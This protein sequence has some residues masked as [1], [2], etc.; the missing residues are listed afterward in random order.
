M[1][2]YETIMKLIPEGERTYDL[3]EITCRC[4]GKFTAL[5]P[6]D[7]RLMTC[8]R[9]FLGLKRTIDDFSWGRF[10]YARITQRLGTY[11]VELRFRGGKGTLKLERISRECLDGFYRR[12]RERIARH[13][14][15]YKMSLK[16]CPACNEIINYKAKRCP[17]CLHEFAQEGK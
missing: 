1:T 13:D 9:G 3:G 6:T 17:H 5:V 8:A 4:S 11:T 2:P 14:E 10:D 16:I 15:K 7:K 12:V